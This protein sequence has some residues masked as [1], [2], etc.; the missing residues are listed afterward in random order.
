VSLQEILTT[1]GARKLQNGI[2]NTG[3][4]SKADIRKQRGLLWC[5]YGRLIWQTQLYS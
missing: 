2:K 3:F 4:Q 1:S 5:V